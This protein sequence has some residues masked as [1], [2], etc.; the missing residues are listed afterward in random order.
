MK[1]ICPEEVSALLV[2]ASKTFFF[3][4]FNLQFTK[5]AEQQTWILCVVA[6]W[7]WEQPCSQ[8]VQGGLCNL[9]VKRLSTVE[10]WAGA[11][12]LFSILIKNYSCFWRDHAKNTINFSKLGCCTKKWNAL[13]HQEACTHA[14]GEI[15]FLLILALL[16]PPTLQGDQV[17]AA[18]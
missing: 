1:G 10:T 6:E 9:Q 13:G 3:F 4:F 18:M 16:I 5:P 7:P 15:P 12:Y 17:P 14:C 11:G 8:L 2:Q